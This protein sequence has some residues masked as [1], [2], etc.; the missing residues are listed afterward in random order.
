M[1]NIILVIVSFVLMS[2]LIVCSHHNMIVYADI[3]NLEYIGNG[4]VD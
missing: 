2:G 3:E 1:K 4:L